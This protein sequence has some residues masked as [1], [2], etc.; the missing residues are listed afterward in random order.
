MEC[1]SMRAMQDD[2][3]QH[4]DAPASPNPEPSRDLLQSELEKALEEHQR[5][6]LAEAERIYRS[7][8]DIDPN[9]FNALN[10]LGATFLERRRF[11]EA[12]E[13]IRRAI[14][15]DPDVA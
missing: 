10:L 5:G 2:M 3:H 14:A 8:L 11:S 4:G 1:R 13:Y 12:E 9:D 7:I 6:N 15:L